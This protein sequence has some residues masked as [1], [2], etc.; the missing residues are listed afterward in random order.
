MYDETQLKIMDATMTLIIDKGYSGAT[1]KDIAKLAGVN[2]STIFRRFD[3]KKEIVMAAMGLPKWN[4]GLSESDFNYHGDLEEDLISFSKIYMSKVTSQMVKVSIGLRSAELQGATLPCI[5]QVPM[6]FKNV[7]L[8]YFAEMIESG[9]M[10]DCDVE[11]VA[12]QFIAMNFGFVFLD[13]SFGNKLVS[14]SKEEY[15][16]NSIRVFVSGICEK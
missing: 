5:I 15:I 9:N 13:A 1:T 2:E 11:S 3:G 12:L 16:R 14:V 10:R 6:V 4:P 7:L 8:N